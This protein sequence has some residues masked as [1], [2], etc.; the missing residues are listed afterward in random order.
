MKLLCPYD[1]ESH[2]L[3]LNTVLAFAPK[4]ISDTR[5][6]QNAFMSGPT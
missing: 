1:Q 3:V 4:R 2:I 6:S 5:A